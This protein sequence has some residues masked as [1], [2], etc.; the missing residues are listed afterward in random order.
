MQPERD[1]A[2]R[3]IQINP[4]KYKQKGLVLFGFP[5]WK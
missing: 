4:R 1:L 5:W 2:P 3:K